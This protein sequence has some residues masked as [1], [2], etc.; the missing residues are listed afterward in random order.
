MYSSHLL[1]P[2]GY[3]AHS[4]KESVSVNFVVRVAFVVVDHDL[5]SNIGIVL[6]PLPR[7]M[8]H[9]L[10]ARLYTNCELMWQKMC[11]QSVHLGG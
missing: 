10:D 5:F 4:C 9:G 8:W 7:Q 6:P 1:S 2:G 11:L 3:F